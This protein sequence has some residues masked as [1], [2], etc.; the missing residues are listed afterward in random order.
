M[1]N[2]ISTVWISSFCSKTIS[3][4]VIVKKHVNENS[5]LAFIQ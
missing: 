5:I 4:Q 2:F 1:E 3:S